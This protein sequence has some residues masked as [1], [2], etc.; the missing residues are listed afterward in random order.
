MDLIQLLVFVDEFIGDF[1]QCFIKF[2]YLY[3]QVLELPVNVGVPSDQCEYEV[4][5]PIDWVGTKVYE[6]NDGGE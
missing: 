3:V 4:A 1:R 5:Q 2:T 6:T